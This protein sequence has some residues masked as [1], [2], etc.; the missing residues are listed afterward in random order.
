MAASTSAASRSMASNSWINAGSAA[1]SVGALSA[2]DRRCSGALALELV[3]HVAGIGNGG[4]AVLLR[5][6]RRWQ[7]EMSE[8]AR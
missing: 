3:D 4:L 8:V 2:A 5:V 6:G 7:T 1:G